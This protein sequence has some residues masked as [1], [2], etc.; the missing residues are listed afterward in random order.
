MQSWVLNKPWMR[1]NAGVG[2]RHEPVRTRRTGTPL[3][4]GCCPREE[5]EMRKA[6]AF[7]FPSFR[8]AYQTHARRRH[9]ECNPIPP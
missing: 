7:S 6:A 1:E 5:K 3:F 9:S 8:D 4:R 2:S